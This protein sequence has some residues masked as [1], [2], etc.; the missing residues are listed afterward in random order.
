MGRG[1]G[2]LQMDLVVKSTSP[3]LKS[4]EFWC[5]NVLPLWNFT[6]EPGIDA[7]TLCRAFGLYI[8]PYIYISSQN[9]NINFNGSAL[10][11]QKHP[12]D[13]FWSLQDSSHHH[14]AHPMRR[15]AL[16]WL[17]WAIWSQRRIGPLVSSLSSSLFWV[18]DNS[19]T[20]PLGPMGSNGGSN[21]RIIIEFAKTHTKH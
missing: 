3:K 10:C 8:F 19:T 16:G 21:G 20:L 18:T 13:P 14:S 2:S 6:K 4:V 11:G 12:L 17:R 7:Y 9:Q 5:F 15:D 1:G